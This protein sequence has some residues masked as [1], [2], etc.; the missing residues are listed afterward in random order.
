MKRLL[1]ILGILCL[2]LGT[3]NGARAAV[4]VTAQ[5]ET[6]TV[7]AGGSVTFSVKA[8]GL[9]KSAITWH[10]ISPDGEEDIT[11]KKLSTRFKGL[12]V[13][14]PNSVN[15][16]LKNVPEELHGWTV[17]CHLG[18]ASAGLDTERALLLIA[19]KE[20]PESAEEPTD[21]EETAE[22]G[23]QTEDGEE[24]DA[25]EDG[26]DSGDNPE[27]EMLQNE[28]ASAPAESSAKR[29]GTGNAAANEQIRGYDEKGGYQ[30][31]QL[32]TYYYKKNGEKQPLVWRILQRNG[33]LLQLITENIIDVKQMINIDDYNKAVKH[34]F[35]S[36]FDEP[37]EQ[38]DIYFWI[39]GE[40]ASTILEKQDFSAAIVPHKVKE[41]I[42]KTKKDEHYVSEEL[43]YPD[44]EI[45]RQNENLTEEEKLLF[46]YGKDLFYI[47]TYG[48]MMNEKN[49][50]PRT[51]AGN[52]VEQEGEVAV[53]EAG[54]RKAFATPYAKEVVQHPGWKKYTSKLTITVWAEYGGASPYW[55]I[56]RRPGYYMVGIIG[57]NGHLSWR[58]MASVMIGVRPAT[59]IDLSKLQVTGGNGSQDKPWVMEVAE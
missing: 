41:P 28:T 52:T 53:P 47:M 14:N 7:E 16:K 51:L 58:S 6:Q 38:M 21:R 48:D 54:R 59:I 8:T 33:N 1:I 31:L 46:P 49:G 18:K 36:R 23:E 2:L 37:Y 32:G 17:Y 10:F 3:V 20:T 30:Y 22:N 5:P 26:D 27:E 56:C 42:K 11:G 39:N 4:T 24:P 50:F 55:T 15:I 19:G 29:T 13:T 45:M 35:K 12:K 25:P 40:M 44:E 9:G 57:G 34:K 43:V